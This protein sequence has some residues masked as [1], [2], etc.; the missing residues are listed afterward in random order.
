MADAFI[1][2]ASRSSDLISVRNTLM[3]FIGLVSAVNR[4]QGNRSVVFS[5]REARLNLKHG[6][7]QEATT[8]FF[9]Q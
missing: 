6:A 9:C 3:L 8:I 2:L 4:R 1:Y 5:R 7:S